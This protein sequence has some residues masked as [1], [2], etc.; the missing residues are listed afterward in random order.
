MPFAGVDCLLLCRKIEDTLDEKRRT[1][2]EGEKLLQELT[3]KQKQ[4]HLIVALI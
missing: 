1:L 2:E 4:L 3:L